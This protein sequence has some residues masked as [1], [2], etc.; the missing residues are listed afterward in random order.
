MAKLP[1]QLTHKERAMRSGIPRGFVGGD[2]TVAYKVAK[3]L[4]LP[5]HTILD[6]GAG[7]DAQQSQLLRQAGFNVTAYDHWGSTE[8]GKAAGLHDENALNRRYHVVMAGNVLNVQGTRRDLAHTLNQIAGAV[9][10]TE[11]MAI[12]AFTK[13]P[14]YDAFKGLDNQQGNASIELSLK[15]RFHSV[16][17]HSMSKGDSPVWI[18]KTPKNPVHPVE[19]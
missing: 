6:F 4:L 12:V 3:T 16:E 7:K 14:R 8:E 15:R 10:P 19:D 17:K 9:H 13:S 5:H 2:R 11:G 18:C 1:G